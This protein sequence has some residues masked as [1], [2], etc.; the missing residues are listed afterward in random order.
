[1]SE[2]TQLPPDGEVVPAPPDLDQYLDEAANGVILRNAGGGWFVATGANLQKEVVVLAFRGTDPIGAIWER[3]ATAPSRS[4]IGPAGLDDVCLSGAETGDVG[5]FR[6]SGGSCCEEHPFEGVGPFDP[7]VHLRDLEDAVD[8]GMTP[9]ERHPLSVFGAGEVEVK[10]GRKADRIEEGQSSQIDQDVCS[11]VEG[12]VQRLA[13][14][15]GG[16]HIQLSAELDDAARTA[17]RDLD[18]Q[19]L[20]SDGLHRDP[21][22]VCLGGR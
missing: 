5:A 12:R 1:M 13:A 3:L 19:R 20:R 15:R 9:D 16:G 7:A 4:V 17:V 11:S 6:G 18:L 8:A 2:G 14:C 22:P 21:L 10:Q